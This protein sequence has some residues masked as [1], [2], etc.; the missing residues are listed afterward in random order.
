MHAISKERSN[1]PMPQ[2]EQE[3]AEEQEEKG[4]AMATVAMLGEGRFNRECV[5]VCVCV[6]VCV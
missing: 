3:L 2:W 1:D 4:V 6:R 5:C